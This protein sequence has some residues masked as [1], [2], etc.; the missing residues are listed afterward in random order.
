[1]QFIP[2]STYCL[3]PRVVRNKM[4]VGFVIYCNESDTP[5]QFIPSITYILSLAA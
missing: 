5:I 2:C 1:M 4:H 3:I